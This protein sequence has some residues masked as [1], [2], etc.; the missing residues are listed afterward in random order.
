MVTDPDRDVTR[1]GGAW[2]GR[3]SSRPAADGTPRLVAGQARADFT[4]ADGAEGSF[5]SIFTA[6]HP[7]LLPAPPEE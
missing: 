4:E 3:F 6:L 2:S 5:D 1:S 7:E